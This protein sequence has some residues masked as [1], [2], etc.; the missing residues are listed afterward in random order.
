[1]SANSSRER[2]TLTDSGADT[3]VMGESTFAICCLHIKLR[4]PMPLFSAI[5]SPAQAVSAK[6]Q[7]VRAR[8][9]R[10]AAQ[11]SG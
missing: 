9:I 5:R 8:W 3:A 11:E 6:E 1:M 2:T 4:L 10:S 7:M